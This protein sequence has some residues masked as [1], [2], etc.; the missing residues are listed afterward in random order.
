M[1]MVLFTA[2][3]NDSIGPEKT[4]PRITTFERSFGGAGEDLGNDVL[5]T[6]DGSCILVGWTDTEGTNGDILVM[7]IDGKGNQIW[8]RVLEGEEFEVAEAIIETADGGYLVTGWSHSIESLVSKVIVVKLDAKGRVVWQSNIAELGHA[9]AFDVVSAPDG[10][11][12][13]AGLCDT[14]NSGQ[15]DVLLLKISSDGE[16]QWRR[17]YGGASYDAAVS[18]AKSPMGGYILAGSTDSFGA[19]KLD[20]YLLAVDDSGLFKWQKTFG[21]IGNDN[22][23]S[24]A[25]DHDGSIL[26]TGGIESSQAGILDIYLLKTDMNGNLLWETTI[27]GKGSERGE[28][29]EILSDGGLAVAGYSSSF[30]S[31]IWD[32]FLVR[33]DDSGKI[34]WQRNYGGSSSELGWAMDKTYDGGFVITGWTKSFGAILH[35]VYLVKTDSNGEVFD[36]LG[37]SASSTFNMEQ[38]HLTD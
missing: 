3:S 33:T 30:A 17:I 31:G 10:G 18:I 11:F 12:V 23:R 29:I 2:C 21:G 36:G 38:I 26:L 19:G 13:I 34:L 28:A 7:K 25:V 4:G 9:I 14:N 16:E 24:V 37:D 1:V 22:I 15:V 32:V 6:A 8:K 35:D 5:S 27:G 20:A